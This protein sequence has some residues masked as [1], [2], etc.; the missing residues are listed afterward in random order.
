MTDLEIYFLGFA[1]IGWCFAGHYY[2]ETRQHKLAGLMLTRSIIGVALGKVK[3]ELTNGGIKL[4]DLEDIDN[5][6]T[7]EQTRQS[8]GTD[9]T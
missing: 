1:L 3:V 7:S 2:L 4:T 8:E 9:R 5:G 6:T